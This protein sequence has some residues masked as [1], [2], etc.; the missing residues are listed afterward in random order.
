MTGT[1][2]GVV[3]LEKPQRWLGEE[4]ALEMTRILASST[5]YNNK[6]GQCQ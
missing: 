3:T 5:F 4:K 2:Y 6:K 1:S